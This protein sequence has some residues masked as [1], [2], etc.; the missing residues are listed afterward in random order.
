LWS[1]SQKIRAAARRR[2]EDRHAHVPSL[3]KSVGDVVTG[4]SSDESAPG[5]LFSVIVC[6]AVNFSLLLSRWRSAAFAGD[7]CENVVAS[8]WQPQLGDGTRPRRV[9][10]PVRGTI[11]KAC[12][13]EAATRPP[14]YLDTPS[15]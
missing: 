8:G 3:I 12:G 2:A 7:L 9:S 11:P 15:A 13:L 5:G 10:L 14:E 6:R 1:F 4:L